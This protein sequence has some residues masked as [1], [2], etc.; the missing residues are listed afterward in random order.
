MRLTGIHL[1]LA[2][3][4]LASPALATTYTVNTSS[5]FNWS[6]TTRWDSA[7]DGYPNA[8]GAE[9]RLTVQGAN[10][11]P[12]V[13]IDTGNATVGKLLNYS[14]TGKYWGWYVSGSN[15]L[16]FDT[17]GPQA[18]ELLVNM[19]SG[20]Q[21][22]SL[23][24]PVVLA[25]DLEITVTYG[26]L[27]L[28]SDITCTNGLKAVTQISGRVN[29]TGSAAIDRWIITSG[30]SLWP[31]EA[32]TLSNILVVV[33]SGGTLKSGTSGDAWHFRGAMIHMN[34]GTLDV[35]RGNNTA[36]LG[37]DFLILTNTTFRIGKSTGYGYYAVTT[38]GKLDF[39]P[40]N[41]LL[42]LL[43]SAAND[44]G[45]A[46]FVDSVVN[47][48]GRIETETTDGDAHARLD[49]AGIAAGATVAKQGGGSMEVKG[50]VGARLR[51]NA[52]LISSTNFTLIDRQAGT[53]DYQTPTYDTADS[54][55]QYNN[56][57]DNTDLTATLT[58]SANKATVQAGG[59]SRSI[60]PP[61]N[62]G[63][64][65]VN[66]LKSGREY[67]WQMVV[68]SNV[69]G[70]ATSISNNAS[71]SEIEVVDETTVRFRFTSSIG[72]TGY[73]AWDNSAVG[74]LGADVV[75]IGHVPMGT[76]LFV[77]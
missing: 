28:N 64:V 36:S 70:V 32:D 42:T 40:G 22:A 35:D 47:N 55:W 62:A 45:Q 10:N 4:L 77:K 7:P 66:G 12:T 72:G 17:G 49:G 27:A 67:I 33:N 31:V 68:T 41:S 60:S 44:Y 43:N 5:D 48:S 14:G 20:N 37:G 56:P 19:I 38:F 63:Y 34:G 61:E 2:L 29:R 52:D 75:K 50:T 26:A 65:T 57:P 21:G 25:S 46:I 9:A 39:G 73:F 1:L 23:N 13:T 53:V 76:V 6:D 58:G 59:P 74:R 54:L 69:T 8:A 16:T 51:G 24:A 18:A 11:P 71:F 30:A 3:A 15:P